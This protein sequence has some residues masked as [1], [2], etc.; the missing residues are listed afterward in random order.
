MII[1]NIYTEIIE[2][3]YQEAKSSGESKIILGGNLGDLTL[4]INTKPEKILSKFEI[5]DD[6]VYIGSDSETSS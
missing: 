6:I 1:S 4:Y 2:Q 5:N 3:K